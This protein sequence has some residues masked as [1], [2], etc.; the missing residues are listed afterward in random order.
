[1]YFYFTLWPAILFNATPLVVFIFFIYLI[2]GKYTFHL[3]HFPLFIPIILALFNFIYFHFFLS[4]PEQ[5]SNINH[6]ITKGWDKEVIMGYF[7]VG[8]MRIIRHSLGFISGFYLLNIYKKFQQ[9]NKEDIN[10]KKINNFYF[11][12]LSSWVIINLSYL[13][14]GFIELDKSILVNWTTLFS[15]IIS[16]LFFI[17]LALYPSL[18][19]GYPLLAKATL[20]EASLLDN[21]IKSIDPLVIEEK[22]VHWENTS[23]AYLSTDFTIKDLIKETGIE[24]DLILFHLTSIKGLNYDAYITNLRISYAIT[25]LEDGFL[26]IN[27]I[28]KLAENAGF[29]NVKTFNNTFFAI[30][31]CFPENYINNGK[32]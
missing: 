32:G 28:V 26:E 6:F 25:L 12:F 24:S 13:I 15:I 2:K 14:I 7:G 5:L 30:M 23:K 1:M 21:R 17:F 31:S 16:F 11:Y 10:K 19:T 9:I 8:L 27:N 29:K 18:M 20:N 22:L 3:F 4:R